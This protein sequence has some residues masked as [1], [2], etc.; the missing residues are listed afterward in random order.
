VESRWVRAEASIAD[1]KGTLIPAKIEPCDL[2]VMFRLT[3]TA[4]VS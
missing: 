2:P 3:Q 1:E 4:R